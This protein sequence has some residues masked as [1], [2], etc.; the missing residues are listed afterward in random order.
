MIGAV[1]EVLVAP[2]DPAP[3][4]STR[5]RRSRRRRIVTLTV[6]EKGYCLDPRPGGLDAIRRRR[7]SG[8]P[9]RPRRPRACRRRASP[10]GATRGCRRS[11]R[12]A[13]TTCRTTAA[14]REAVLEHGRTHDRTCGLDRG[15]RRLPHT[16]V[17]RIVPA[18]TAEADRGHA[19][20]AGVRD[21]ALVVTEPFTQWVIEDRFAG[22]RPASAGRRA[23]DRG[24]RAVGGRQ[25]A[26]AQRRPFGARLSRWAGGLAHVHEAVA[27]A[28]RRALIERLWDESGAELVRARP[29]STLPPMARR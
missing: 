14:L 28:D 23:A 3:R 25:A 26:A 19:A 11:P 7:R 5:D 10:R 4:W 15:R 9:R 24:R 16:M 22:G 20:A 21:E 8:R 18:T 27:G 12:S 29:G 17:D 13:A 6:T 1:R 2:D